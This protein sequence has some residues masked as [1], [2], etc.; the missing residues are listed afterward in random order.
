M[1]C[2]NCHSVM[3]VTD[4]TVSD[5]SHVIFYRC[6]VCTSEQVSSEPSQQASSADNGDYFDSNPTADRPGYFMI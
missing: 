6:S 2:Q 4:E 1:K 5:R 3:F